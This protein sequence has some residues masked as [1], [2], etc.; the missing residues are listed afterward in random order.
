MLLDNFVAIIGMLLVGLWVKKSK[1]FSDSMVMNLNS[2][3]INISLPAIIIIS[4]ADSKLDFNALIP[5]LIHWPFFF[6]HFL[7]LYV[8]NKFF[9]FDKKIFSTLVIVT[10]LGNTAFLGIPLMKSY[11]GP[12]SISYAILYDQLGSGIGFIIMG[13]FYIPYIKGG[14]SPSIKTILYSLFTFPAFIA[15]TLGFLAQLTGINSTIHY[16][17]SS[18]AKTLIPCA[19]IAV[20][21]QMK[22]RLNL[23]ILRPLLFGLSLKLLVLPLIL[24][25]V[26]KMMKVE[27][28]LPVQVSV[29][30]AAM[31]PMVTAGALAINEGFDE[32]LSSSL[33]GYGLIIAFASSYFLNF[34]IS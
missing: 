34:L 16:F 17:L 29:L 27:M 3:V 32:D 4:I 23:S 7:F 11:F 14:K 15:L 8:L 13:A 26:L 31:P 20:G 19:I 9:K 28:D 5:F 1:L 30:Q 21:A 12:E 25:L 24:I 18:I 2:F 10:T 6:I 33:V 22:Y